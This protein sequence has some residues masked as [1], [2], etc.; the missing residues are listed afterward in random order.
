MLNMRANYFCN[1][2]ML[3]S[4]YSD[5]RKIAVAVFHKN[6]SINN[7]FSQIQKLLKKNRFRKEL[8]IKLYLTGRRLVRP[9]ADD[10]FKV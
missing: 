8:T 7:N 9:A 10:D 1:T 6:I 5:F 4:A 3:D 2:D